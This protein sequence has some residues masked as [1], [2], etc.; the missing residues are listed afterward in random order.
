M[1]NVAIYT[2]MYFGC[3]NVIEMLWIFQ[4]MFYCINRIA[5][6]ESSAPQNAELALMKNWIGSFPKMEPILSALDSI[7]PSFMWVGV[8]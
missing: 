3:C 6:K 1:F 4:V 2:R 7:N 5:I 8:F